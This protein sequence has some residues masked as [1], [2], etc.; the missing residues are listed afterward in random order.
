MVSAKGYKYFTGKLQL[1]GGTVALGFSTDARGKDDMITLIM[2]PTTNDLIIHR[3][4]KNQQLITNEWKNI[5]DEKVFQLI[6]EA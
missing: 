2:Y 4:N 5:S 3:Y 1:G 6:K